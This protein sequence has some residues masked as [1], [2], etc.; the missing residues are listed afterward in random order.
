MVESTPSPGPDAGSLSRWSRAL[1]AAFGA[2][3]FGTGVAAVFVTDNGTG[4]GALLVIGGIALV[5]AIL[6]PRIDSLEFGG[7][8]LRLRAAAAAKYALAERSERAGDLDAADRLR[9]EAEA[10]MAAAGPIAAEY[11]QV[12][13]RMPGGRERTHEMER[14]IE[15]ARQL[16]ATQPFEPAELA[17]WLR[18]GDDNERITALA[19]MQARPELGDLDG[20]L[21]A[22][23]DPRSAFEQYQALVLAG[24]M[25]DGMAPADRR[26]LDDTVRAAR[27]LRFRQDTGRWQLSEDIL[28]RLGT[29]S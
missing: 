1:L 17:R 29:G 22:I 19:M 4:A 10:L 26:R 9:V 7:A 13:A 15:Q 2:G 18:R 12:R 16:A 11:G 28:A 21:A 14:V 6:A 25:I 3:S 5:L 27:G 24:Q 23:A 20:V 8:R